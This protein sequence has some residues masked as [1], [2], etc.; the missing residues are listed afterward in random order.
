MLLDLP[1]LTSLQDSPLLLVAMA[2]S[3]DVW[4]GGA[5]LRSLDDGASF[6]QPLDVFRRVLPLDRPVRRSAWSIRASSI[7]PRA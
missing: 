6:D 4:P 5:L 2:G 3:N 7:P 1:R